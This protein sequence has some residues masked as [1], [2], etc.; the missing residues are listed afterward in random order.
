[1]IGIFDSGYGG[2][3]VL[4]PIREFLP[5]YEYIYLGDNAR[6]PYGNHEEQRIQEFIEEA[7]EYLFKKGASVVVLACN[8]ASGI[9]LRH[10]QEKNKKMLKSENKRI[11][12]VLIPIAEFVAKK[13]KGKRVGIIGTKATIKSGVYE[14]EIKKIN[15]DIQVFSQACPLLVPL[16]EENYHKKPEARSILKKYLMPLKN[17]NIDTLVLGCTHYSFMEKE[18]KRFMGKRV[19]IVN[20]GEIMGQSLKEYL[21]RHPEIEKK[22]KKTKKIQF[23]TTEDPENFKKF[24]EK[25]CGMKIKTPKRVK[26]G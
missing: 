18:I 4:K 26:L 11:L 17:A 19:E 15:P 13:T 5:Q 16:I 6:A 24:V 21:S 7:T 8:T 9:A 10:V 2:V 1:M 22:L 23:L 12:G 14:K 3:T 25:N 20:S